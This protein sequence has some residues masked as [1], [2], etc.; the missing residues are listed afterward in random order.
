MLLIYLVEAEYE[1]HHPDTDA[2]MNEYWA[3]DAMLKEGGHLVAADALG[4]TSA[5]STVRVR[6]GEVQ[7]VDGPFAETREQL[8]G[9]YIVDATDLDQAT[10]L[11]VKVPDACIGSIEVRPI[12]QFDPPPGP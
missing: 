8:A 2:I 11:A 5:A 7:T 3:Y 4:P 9:F 6:N 12:M 10:Q 1:T